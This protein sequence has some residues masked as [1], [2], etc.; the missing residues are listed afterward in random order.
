MESNF[1][2]P[3]I[4]RLTVPALVVLLAP[5]M[6]SG[7]TVG[8]GSGDT[9]VRVLFVY[10]P[11]LV[12]SSQITAAMNDVVEAWNVTGLPASTGLTITIANNGQAL[13]YIG[14]FSTDVA[15]ALD[16]LE[17]YVGPPSSGSA[18]SIRDQNAADIVIGIAADL[19]PPGGGLRC[20]RAPQANWITA[21]DPATTPSNFDPNADGVI[22][23]LDLRGAEKGSNRGY[24]AMISVDPACPSNN[25]SHE[26]GHL[27]GAGHVIAF[28]PGLDSWVV[29]EAHA[30]KKITVTVD[31]NQNP[32]YR[33]DYTSVTSIGE[34]CNLGPLGSAFPCNPVSRYSDPPSWGFDASV[35]HPGHDNKSAIEL[36]AESISAYRRGNGLAAS[37]QCSDGLDN[38]GNGL[39]DAGQ[40]P[41][42]SSA[43]DDSELPGPPAPPLPGS[44]NSTISP[45]NYTGSLVR[46]CVP[47]TSSTEYLLEWQHACPQNVSY[48]EVIYA[49]PPGAPIVSGWT[50]TTLWSRAFHTGAPNIVESWVKSCGPAGCSPPSATSF[51]S[52]DQC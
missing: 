11:F 15:Q 34:R 23:G 36:T 9:S 24:V 50:K 30:F 52:L 28:P 38:D 33:E 8:P 26:F 43:S 18:R 37:S 13:D 4:G 42:C 49:A 16:D 27:F 35:A 47:G 19:T 22:D 12:T 14:S 51:I 41:N 3:M 32:I 1:S 6:A 10:D 20:G 39:V 25:P 40:D 21:R 17:D 7:Q 46:K 2:K 44:C 48:Y 31:G 29:P 45:Y 5:F